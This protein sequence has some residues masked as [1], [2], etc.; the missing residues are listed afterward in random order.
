MIPLTSLVREAGQ[1]HIVGVASEKNTTT[2][3]FDWKKIKNTIF[4]FLFC[5]GSIFFLKIRKKH[6]L[7]S[8]CFFVE[9]ENDK[10]DD[11]DDGNVEDDADID[12]DDDDGNDEDDDLRSDFS[13]NCS[14][15]CGGFT[16]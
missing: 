13:C 15:S 16:S 1:Q 5:F 3:V 11:V 4:L 9:A 7:V 12:A 14:Q 8:K 6:F 2:E 10:D